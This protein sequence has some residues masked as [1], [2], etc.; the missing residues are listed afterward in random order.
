MNFWV[1][2]TYGKQTNHRD[3]KAANPSTEEQ[4]R[5]TIRKHANQSTN[6]I[7][8]SPPLFDA[9]VYTIRVYFSLNSVKGLTVPN[10]S[11]LVSQITFPKNRKQSIKTVY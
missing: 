10:E 4:Q 11:Q 3:Q 1:S 7:S 5:Q 8:D 9:S 2:G 6:D